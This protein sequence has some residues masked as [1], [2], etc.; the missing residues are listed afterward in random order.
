MELTLASKFLLSYTGNTY[1]LKIATLTCHTYRVYL[2]V[3]PDGQT[4]VTGAGDETS[5]FWNVFLSMKAQNKSLRLGENIMHR[6]VSGSYRPTRFASV[7]KNNSNKKSI[8]TPSEALMSSTLYEVEEEI[9]GVHVKSGLYE[10]GRRRFQP[11]RSFAGSRISYYL[12]RD[13]DT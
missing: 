5:R 12:Y 4:I 11:S 7:P 1:H 2:A 10:V 6:T 8:E 3:S 9:V 13:D